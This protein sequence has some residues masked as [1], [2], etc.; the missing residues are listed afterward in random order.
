M[1]FKILSHACLWVKHGA[2]SVIIDPWLIGSCYW[3]SWWN[4]PDPVFDEED[5]RAV[6]AVI[7]SHIH[8]DH[9][10][11]PTLKK[12]LSGK[13]VIVPD[14]PG[15]RSAQDL[16]IIGYKDICRV[17]HGHHV[18]IGDLKITLYQ[19]GLYLN[20]CAVVVEGGGTVLLNAN[21]AKIAG[22]VLQQIVNNHSPI[23]FAF[24]SHSSANTRICYEV[25][26]DK[27]FISDDREHYFRSFM[28]FMDAV[29][30]NYAVPFASNHCHLHEDVLA[31]NSYISNPLELRSYYESQGHREWSLQVMLPGSCWSDAEGFSLRSEGVFTNLEESL[32]R[33][34]ESIMPILKKYR[35]EEQAV[36]ITDRILQR[37]MDYFNF[38]GKPNKVNGKFLLKLKWPDSN[39]QFYCCDI[40]KKN[41]EL[42]K[43]IEITSS[44]GLPLIEM[45]AIIFR[46][47]VIKNMFHHAGISK[48]CRYLAVNI[49][50]MTRLRKIVGFLDNCELGVYPRRWSY[51]RRMFMAYL[52]RWRELL[53]YLHAVWLI[54]IRR[55][56]IYLV[57]EAV[58]QGRF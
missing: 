42:L 22:Y 13:R 18:N 17:R 15:M 46:D 37:F 43:G 1:Q 45:P 23:D 19:F 32:V 21:D 52:P 56:P 58:L 2:T 40:D 31:F 44:S 3:R 29:R 28:Y 6:D 26:G 16:K 4:F 11:G 14:E 5:I 54:K 47:A 7:I 57:E 35:S 48:R 51:L 27:E 8:W 39:L 20:D 41:I 38:S 36:K 30:P 53:V 50:D 24:R 10:H 34:R 25:T 55:M 49:H 33:Q 9:W 12:F